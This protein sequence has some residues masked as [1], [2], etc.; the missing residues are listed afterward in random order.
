[1]CILGLGWLRIEHITCIFP[2]GH[3]CMPVIGLIFCAILG[4]ITGWLTAR[5]ESSLLGAII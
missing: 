3:A 4:G 1:M 2:M 5:S